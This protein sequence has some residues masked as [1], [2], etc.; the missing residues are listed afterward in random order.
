MTKAMFSLV[1]SI[2][3]GGITAFALWTTYLRFSLSLVVEYPF[4]QLIIISVWLSINCFFLGRSI[5]YEALKGRTVGISSE[6]LY[7]YRL[8]FFTLA[9]GFGAGALLGLFFGRAG[10]VFG[11]VLFSILGGGGY[12]LITRLLE[13]GIKPQL[14]LL[15]WMI[16]SSGMFIFSQFYFAVNLS[17]ILVNLLAGI[18]IFLLPIYISSVLYNFRHLVLAAFSISIIGLL[19]FTLYR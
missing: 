2:L 6:P 4:N 5:F 10:F 14:A 17:S 13:V 19:I 3:L 15:F 7:T 11:L 18:V 9:L 8:L 16:P 12:I 1:G